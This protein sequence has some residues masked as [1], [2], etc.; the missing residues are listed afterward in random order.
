MIRRVGSLLVLGAL[1]AAAVCG[2]GDT[3]VTADRASGTPASGPASGGAAP[4]YS[5]SGLYNLGNAYAR[6][7]KPGMAVLNYERAALLAPADPDIEAN[8]ALVRAGSR[9][10]P[11][12]GTGL[13]RAVTRAVAW[14][15][16]GVLAWLGVAGIVFAGAGAL[17]LRFGAPRGTHGG[18]QWA[19]RLRAACVA[20]IVAGVLLIG[21]TAAH[22]M[23]LW[24]AL[25]EAVV[26]TAI[27]PARVS[28]VPMSEPSFELHEAETVRMEAEHEGF[29]LVQTRGGRTGWVALANLAPVVP[30]K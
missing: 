16:P 17:G 5:V 1:A 18:V 26:V 22:A 27:A 12:P 19:A 25:H 21:L 29:V 24:P 3:A 6:A 20:G 30:R 23:V 8:L 15:P 4:G 11:D 14:P 13:T 2:A 10:P 7:G 28:P 9:L